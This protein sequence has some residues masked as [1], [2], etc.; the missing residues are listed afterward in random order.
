[1]LNS[2]SRYLLLMKQFIEATFKKVCAL[3]VRTQVTIAVV[4][5]YFAFVEYCLELTHIIAIY[6]LH[7]R[8]SPVLINYNS[9]CAY[10][11]SQIQTVLCKTAAIMSYYRYVGGWLRTNVIWRK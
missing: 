7:L 5:Q 8:I 3:L 4:V 6:I 2:V 10:R 11:V 1:M 9:V